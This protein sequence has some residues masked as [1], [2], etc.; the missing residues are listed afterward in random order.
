M[1]PEIYL[2]EKIFFDIIIC[3]LLKISEETEMSV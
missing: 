3:V 2:T 1:F